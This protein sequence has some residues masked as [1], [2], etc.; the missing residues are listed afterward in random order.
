MNT[1]KYRLIGR[2]GL[3]GMTLLV[4]FAGCKK[5]EQSVLQIARADYQ[6]QQVEKTYIGMGLD[7]MVAYWDDTD[8]VKING[9]SYSLTDINVGEAK[10]EN[11]SP[12]SG[13]YFAVYPAYPSTNSINASG[14]GSVLIPNSQTYI[15]KTVS[16][17][18][19]QVINAPMAA[20]LPSTSGILYF[21]NVAGLLRIAVMNG[22]VTQAGAAGQNFTVNSITITSLRN[23]KLCG[24]QAF[25][26]SGNSESSNI[27]I[28]N[29]TGGGQ[30]V[31]L[32]NCD[33]AGSIASGSMKVF[34]IVVAPYSSDTLSIT[35]NG[36]LGST[37]A[38]DYTI[39]QNTARSISAGDVAVQFFATNFDK[40]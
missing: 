38:K 7:D 32:T 17:T 23:A 36:E 9:S 4:C 21:R 25:S 26:Y 29:L 33:R 28:G 2:S 37:G 22:N 13:K 24:T 5:D 16:G 19:R 15:E 39:K 8:H 35:I 40:Q 11:V 6:P 18:T 34:N 27:S 12:S 10:A 31:T 30:T 3:V 14:S 1:G 20:Y